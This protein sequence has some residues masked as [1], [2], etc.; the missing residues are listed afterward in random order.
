MSDRVWVPLHNFDRT[1][2]PG[3]DNCRTSADTRVYSR[4]LTPSA[5]PAHIPEPG[6]GWSPRDSFRLGLLADPTTALAAPM[7]MAIGFSP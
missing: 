5:V 4:G 6:A 7:S 2:G 3:D 1:Q